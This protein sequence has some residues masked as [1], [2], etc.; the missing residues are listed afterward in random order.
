MEGQDVDN[1]T[2]E[3]GSSSLLTS[4]PG[5]FLWW[6]FLLYVLLKLFGHLTKQ[7]WATLDPT[8]CLHLLSGWE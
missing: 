6:R 2:W 5:P 3:C 8:S 4:P 1:T 7:A